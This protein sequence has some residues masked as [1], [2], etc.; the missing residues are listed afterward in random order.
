MV[1]SP[2]TTGGAV[3]KWIWTIVTILLAVAGVI[4]GYN[5]VEALIAGN[6]SVVS[7]VAQAGIVILCLVVAP[8]TYA[9]AKSS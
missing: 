3:L 7:L 5:T 8:R 1:A 6:N 2:A 9:K 4:G